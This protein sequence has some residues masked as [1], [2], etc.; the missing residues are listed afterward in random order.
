LLAPGTLDAEDVEDVEGFLEP[1]TSV[2]ILVFENTWAADFVTRLFEAGAVLVDSAR[3]PHDTAEK[4]F[5]EFTE[6]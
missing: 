3:L 5:A 1:D 2:A 6:G 4:V